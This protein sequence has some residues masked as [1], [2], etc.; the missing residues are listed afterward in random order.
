MVGIFASLTMTVPVFAR[1][2]TCECSPCPETPAASLPYLRQGF[3]AP[4]G[5]A[6]IQATR[7]MVTSTT[8]VAPVKNVINVEKRSC[9]ANAVMNRENALQ[10]AW[11]NWKSSMDNAMNARRNALIAN[12]NN[13]KTVGDLRKNIK[14]SWAVFYKSKDTSRKEFL[15]ARAM[16]WNV[17][18]KGRK[19]CSGVTMESL[20]STMPEVNGK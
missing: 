18:S 1:T 19:S 13:S 17:F 16:A 20:I 15:N 9:M 3:S 2:C 11:N 6:T 4:L 7:R 14:A 10:T 8:R 5:P 12:Y